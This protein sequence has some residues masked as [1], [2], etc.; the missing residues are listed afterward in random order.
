MTY[1]TVSNT[2]AKYGR[3]LKCIQK[4]YD[5]NPNTTVRLTHNEIIVIT[6]G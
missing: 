4:K 1:D 3:L 2:Y 6:I 5:H